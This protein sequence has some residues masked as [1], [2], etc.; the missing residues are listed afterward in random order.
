MLCK[1]FATTFPHG[2]EE[3]VNGEYF[4][5]PETGLNLK[6]RQHAHIDWYRNIG[7]NIVKTFR[8]VYVLYRS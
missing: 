8:K 5:S 3:T 1:E 4:T 7:L 6:K 2:R